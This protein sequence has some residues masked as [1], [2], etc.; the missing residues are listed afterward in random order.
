MEPGVF[1]NLDYYKLSRFFHDIMTDDILFE[2]NFGEQ[3]LN[4][5]A[6]IFGFE[7]STF[8][9]LNPDKDMYFPVAYRIDGCVIEEYANKYYK[10]DP[11]YPDNIAKN[12]INDSVVSIYDIMTLDEYDSST[13]LRKFL[14]PTKL[15]YEIVLYLRHKGIIIGG[16]VLLKSKS[17]GN[18]TSKDINLM[19]IVCTY[20][21]KLTANYMFGNDLRVRQN[22]FNTLCSQSPVGLIVFGTYYP[23]KIDFINSSAIRYISDILSEDITNNQVEKFIKQYIVSSLNFEQYGLYKT[24]LSNSKKIYIL[25]VVPCHTDDK[26]TFWAYAYI[27]P[28]NEPSDS[29][30]F[31]NIQNYDGLTTRQIEIVNCVLKGYTNEEISKR[32]FISVSTV[33][34]HLNNIYKELKVSNRISLHSKIIGNKDIY[35]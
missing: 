28:Q 35:S 27:I 8:W 31:L 4:S 33:K 9:M 11:F 13:Y 15:Y 19:K 34:T 7:K 22:M 6:D 32:L 25:N 14:A 24:V 3:L 1:D 30:E 23:Y 2:G 26:N 10:I 17:E 21:S 18:F 12:M 16:I 20:I 5:I 29:N